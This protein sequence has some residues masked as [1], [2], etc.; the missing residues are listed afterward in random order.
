MSFGFL[1]LFFDTG[2]V[3]IKIVQ[4]VTETGFIQNRRRGEDVVEEGKSHFSLKSY[5]TYN[6][7]SGLILI[8]EWFDLN[9]FSG[10]AEI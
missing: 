6:I 3:V 9:L 10:L 5:G 7:S 8:F 4:L 1:H 2:W